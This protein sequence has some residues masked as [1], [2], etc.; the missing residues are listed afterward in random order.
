LK[1]T[2]PQQYKF[3]TRCCDQE[4]AITSHEKGEAINEMTGRARQ[5]TYETLKHNCD[6]LADLEASMGYD[7]HLHLKDDY[8]VSFWK[9][10]YRG[11]RAFYI[12]HSRIEHIFVHQDDLHLLH[13]PNRPCEP[14]I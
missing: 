14:S 4:R 10:T 8:A 2:K 6:G 3:Y 1:R 12:D 11:A 9:S 5:I 7:R 13:E